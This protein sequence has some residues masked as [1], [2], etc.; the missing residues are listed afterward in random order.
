MGAEKL[1]REGVRTGVKILP[2]QL[3]IFLCLAITMGVFVYY[4]GFAKPKDIV[5]TT[6]CNGFNITA[7]QQEVCNAKEQADNK[8]YEDNKKIAY[9]VG[10]VMFVILVFLAIMIFRELN[11][12]VEKFD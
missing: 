4:F 6:G 8:V 2:Y 3:G 5:F 1:V 7:E 11:K 9:I 12:F 10:A